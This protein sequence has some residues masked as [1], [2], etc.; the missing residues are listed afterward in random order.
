MISASQALSW[1]LRRH[2]LAE[3]PDTG[4][5]AEVAGRLCGLHAQ[6]MG[7]ADL[8]VLARVGRHPPTALADALWRDRSLV[9]TWAARGT[10]HLLPA[11]ELGMWLGA[12]GTM[13]KF[14]NHGD[15][16]TQRICEAVGPALRGRILTRDELADEVG[17]ST[18]SDRLADWVRSSWGSNLKAAA[19]RG[20]LCFAEPRG[21]TVRFTAPENWVGKIGKPEGSVRAI[22]RRFL[23]GYAPATAES[24]ARWW[25]GPPR[26]TI[27]QGLLDLLGDEA[28]RVTFA[29][30]DAWVLAE[31]LPEMRQASASRAYRLL[32]AFDPWVLAMAR[33]EPFVR[34]ELL[35]EVFRPAGRIAPVVLAGGRIAGR[36]THRTEKTEVHLSIIPFEP[37]N[38][39][40]RATLTAEAERIAAHLGRP[41]HLSWADS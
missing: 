36:W 5:P 28:V 22:V 3:R 35:P 10:L 23:Q 16:D 34:P 12:L 7:S 37:I 29:G 33:D 15:P 30:R 19:F 9:K 32:P 31:D 13:R 4:D 2:G 8:S 40:G 38:R 39:R 26:V 18:G 6:V 14:G 17:R 25:V 27:G 21:N 24:I 11:A 20:L 1:R 41:L